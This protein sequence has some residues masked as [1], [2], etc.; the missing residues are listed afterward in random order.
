MVECSFDLNGKPMSLFKMNNM[1]FQA[2]SG[3]SFAL[4]AADGKIDD[5]TFCNKVKRGSFR[6]HP[7]GNLGISHRETLRSAARSPWFYWPPVQV[8]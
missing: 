1:Q 8:C 2:F 6:L 3:L 5:E 7:T 4:C